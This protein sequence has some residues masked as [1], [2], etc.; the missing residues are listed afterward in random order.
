MK[1]V[2]LI[3]SNLLPGGAAFVVRSFL[4]VKA[5]NVGN[6]GTVLVKHTKN[7]SIAALH[8]NQPFRNTMLSIVSETRLLQRLASDAFPLLLHS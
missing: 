5:L 2:E 8:I 6:L 3:R 1:N 4:N 7:G